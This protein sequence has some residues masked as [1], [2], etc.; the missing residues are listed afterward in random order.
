M[1]IPDTLP[2][3]IKLMLSVGFGLLVKDSLGK[4]IPGMMFYLN[5]MFN[6]GDVVLLN[7]EECVIT[8]IGIRNTAF[9]RVAEGRIVWR[10]IQNDLLKW[11]KLEKV[12]KERKETHDADM[13]WEC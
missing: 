3:L 10:I 11:E 13:D 5:Q 4:F 6:E 2:G 12:I 1:E 7:G 8:K 9:S